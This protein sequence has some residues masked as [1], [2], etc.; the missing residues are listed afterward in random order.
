MHG[1]RAVHHR[2]M[3]ERA[4]MSAAGDLGVSC[5]WHSMRDQLADPTGR[6]QAI[7]SQRR[8]RPGGNRAEPEP[9]RQGLIASS[10]PARRTHGVHPPGHPLRQHPVAALG[11]LWVHPEPLPPVWLRP[12][13]NAA[14]A[15]ESRVHVGG[16]GRLTVL[17]GGPLY[18]PLRHAAHVPVA[19]PGFRERHGDGRGGPPPAQGDVPVDHG[20]RR[21]AAHRGVDHGALA[22][23]GKALGHHG[24]CG[25][26]P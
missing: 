16:G 22:G 8:L 15:H 10:P 4:H 13:R 14:D 6:R 3:G 18:A 26:V 9:S 21:H 1:N 12:I 19:D 11:R 2:G 17:P 25:A 24:P 20:A 7:R 5:A 23:A